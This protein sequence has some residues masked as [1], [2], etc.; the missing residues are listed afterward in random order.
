MALQHINSQVQTTPTL[1]AQIP[2]SVGRNIAVQIYNNHSSAIYIGNESIA[3]SGA[4]IGRPMSATSSFQLWLNGG[5]KI[6]AI[7]A[8]QTAAGACIVT[9]SA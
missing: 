2:A 3:T 8:A 9:F 6:Y 5:D 7:S 4:T 1:I